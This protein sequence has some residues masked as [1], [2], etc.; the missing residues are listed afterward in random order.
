MYRETAIC[1][2]AVDTAILV[3]LRFV[4]S[5]MTIS[6]YR[7]ITRNHVDKLIRRYVSK[8]AIS[9]QSNIKKIRN[10]V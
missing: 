6:R 4:V 7:C 8:L 1:I 10:G 9:V 3:S 5:V 2:K